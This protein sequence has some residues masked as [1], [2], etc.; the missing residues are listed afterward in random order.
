MCCDSGKYV[1]S[2]SADLDVLRDINGM[3]TSP[4]Q[5]RSINENENIVGRKAPN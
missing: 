3:A 2:T 4:V 5:K 1:R